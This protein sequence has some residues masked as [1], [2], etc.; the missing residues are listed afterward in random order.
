MEVHVQ[1]FPFLGR[2]PCLWC[3]IS[4]EQMKIP[5]EERAPVAPRTLDSLQVD[6]LLSWQW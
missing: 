5:R 1:Y 4:L 2:H 3:T 6:H